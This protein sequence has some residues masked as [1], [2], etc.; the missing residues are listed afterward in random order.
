[1][2][3]SVK[4]WSEKLGFELQQLGKYV[5]QI[6]KFHENYKDVEI[7][8]IVGKSLVET[9]ASHIEVMMRSKVDAIQRIMDVAE[10][11]ALA[12]SL[13]ESEREQPIDESYT[14]KDAKNY[15]QVTTSYSEHFGGDVNLN[16]SAVHVPTTVYG[17]AKET[18]R[19]IRWSEELDNTFKYN[20]KQDPSLSWQYFGSSTGFMRHYPALHWKPNGSNPHDPDLF[21]CRTRSWY[22]E[23]A[24][25][26]KDVLILV[27]TS[28]S[29]TGMRKEIA[30]HVVN[31]ILDTLGNNDYV[32]I[33]KFSNIT[34]QAVPCFEDS[35][36]Q[37]NLAN[38]RELKIGIAE[39]NTERIA[40]F[41]MIL[42]YAFELLQEFRETRRGACCNQAIM[43]VTDGVPDN[44]KEIFQRF[45]WADSPENPDRADMPVRIFTYL[46]GRE[47]A[48]VRDSRWMA[49]ANRGYF[50]H[51]STLAEVREQVLNYISVM[52]RPL[53]LNLTTHPTVWTPVY[54]DIADPKITDWLW[55]KKERND[56]K[57]RYWIY[58]RNKK[59]RNLPKELE[60]Y[61]KRTKKNP[62]LAGDMYKYRL[63]TSVSMPV[64][65]RREN[66]N[67]TEWVLIKNA[68]WVT[69]TREVGRQKANANATS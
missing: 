7:K 51:L 47:V 39:M 63:M 48:D 10:S 36:V 67:I 34:E 68:Y 21:D 14:Y 6:D 28:G 49:C 24:N 13:I 23:A 58:R 64:F 69:E 52:A 26:P 53:V 55:D 40:N 42:T 31:N 9:I 62:N 38:I 20:Y 19:A 56:Q 11:S 37:A 29:M 27:D 65:D 59:L 22:I 12:S 17:R 2:N 3:G 61:V 66:A 35:L 57:E 43:L 33:V 18:L 44:Y 46:I 4:T 1:M 5:T 41:S 45:N 54:A 50:V 15:S 32:N 16:Y 60:Q 30:R 8:L 25:S